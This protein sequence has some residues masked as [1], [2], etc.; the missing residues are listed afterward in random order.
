MSDYKAIINEELRDGPVPDRKCTDLFFCLLFFLFLCSFFTI[1]AIGFTEGDPSLLLYP[2]DSSGSQCGRPNTPSSSYPYLYYPAA[3]TSSPSPSSYR[4]CLKSCPLSNSTSIDCYENFEVLCPGHSNYFYITD[5]MMVVPPYT[6]KALWGRFC[7]PSSNLTFFAS[8]VDEVHSS[9]IESWV[10]DVFRCWKVT[11][12]VLGIA[13]GVSVGYLILM[14]FCAEVMIW[15]TIIF[16]AVMI[17]VF[18]VYMDQIANRNFNDPSEKKT[19]DS[20][21]IA[22][23]VM[24]GLVGVFMLVVVFMYRRIHL[25]IAIMKSGAIFIKDVPSILLVPILM[26]LISCVLL[27]YW[28]LAIIFIYSSG[29]LEKGN[30]VIA[31]ISWDN[32]TRHSL[33]FELVGIIWI[34][35]FKVA[36]TQFIIACSVCFW[37]FSQE[38]SSVGMICKSIGYAMRYHLGTLALGSLVLSMVKLLKYILW[39]IHEK[40]Y[41]A[42]F[43]GNACIKFGCMCLECYAR[44]FVRF[45]QFLDKH[46]YI[47][48]ALT[49]AGFCE[50]A[51]NA[52]ALMAENA[53]RFATLGAIGDI[54]KILGKIFVTVISTYAGFIIINAWEPYKSEIESPLGPVCIFALVSYIV[55]G[56]FMAVHEMACDTIIQTFLVDEHIHKEAFFAPEPLKEFIKEH[57]D[58][59]HR[60]HCCGCL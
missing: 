27:A 28:V 21:K 32:T 5:E 44:C 29:E 52:F 1:G 51:R 38:N 16:T 37:Y 11:L 55:S 39:Y 4:V 7:V 49:G 3:S 54:F 48:T 2:Y 36:L 12:M 33:Y 45:I 59:E 19:H 9:G 47:Q 25:A 8:V 35:S 23:Y 60:A 10:S 24:Y 43:Q 50:A 46:A 56:I 57:R 22:G 58:V 40:V 6:S 17:V 18:G 30:S 41:K 34:N 14:R 42:G 31:K 15:I 53:L 26:F 20:L 13:C